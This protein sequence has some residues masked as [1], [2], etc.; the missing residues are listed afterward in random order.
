MN[1]IAKNEKLMTTKELANILGV[2]KTTITKTVKRLEE[3][4]AVLHHL[5]NDEF[6]NTVWI[7]N[8]QQA[9]LIKQEI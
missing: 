4:G 1:E 6:R 9:T 3:G 5:T 7:F 2:D 8:E